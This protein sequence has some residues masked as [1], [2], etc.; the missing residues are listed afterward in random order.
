[1]WKREDGAPLWWV[2]CMDYVAEVRSNKHI[3]QHEDF[4]SEI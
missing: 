1:M 2:L 4:E 3:Q